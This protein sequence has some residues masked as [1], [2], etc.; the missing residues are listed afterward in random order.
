MCVWLCF[1]LRCSRHVYYLGWGSLALLGL[2]DASECSP[3]F[4]AGKR[5]ARSS[6]GAKLHCHKENVF[7]FFLFRIAT[8][9]GNC[10]CVCG[11][12]YEDVRGFIRGGYRELNNNDGPLT[13]LVC[14][15]K[16]CNNIYLDKR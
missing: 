8:S 15:R 4:G 10:V 16:Q 3:T 1:S 2:I 5:S 6:L 13:S 14:E 11:T 7:F 12:D 9:D